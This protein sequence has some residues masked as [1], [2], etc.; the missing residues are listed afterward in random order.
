MWVVALLG[1]GVG[2]V[3]GTLKKNWQR[4]GKQYSG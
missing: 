1:A 4:E 3:V 2:D